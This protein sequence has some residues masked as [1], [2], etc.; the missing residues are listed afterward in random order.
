MRTGGQNKTHSRLERWNRL[1]SYQCSKLAGGVTLH[2]KNGSAI[3][4]EPTTGGVILDY[5]VNGEA[6]SQPLYFERVANNYGGTRAFFLCP[7][8][9]GRV[10]FLYCRWGR[11]RCRECASLNY[12][13][14]QATKD[15]FQPYDRLKRLLRTKLGVKNTPVPLDIVGFIP[16]KPK[17]MRWATYNRLCAEVRRLEDEYRATFIGRAKAVLGW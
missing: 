16:P 4:A 8:C 6:V 14:Q 1:D 17:G 3:D 13:S 12:D 2:W 11:F 15:E 10:R 7:G 5:S 9:G